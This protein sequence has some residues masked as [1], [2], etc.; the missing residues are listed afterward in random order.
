MLVLCDVGRF[1]WRK[2]SCRCV[3]VFHNSNKFPMLCPWLFQWS[4]IYWCWW[5]LFFFAPHHGREFY[6]W[7]HMQRQKEECL[8]GKSKKCV[9]ILL[10][11]KINIFKWYSWKEILIP[12]PNLSRSSWTHL[13]AKKC[14]AKMKFTKR[15]SSSVDRHFSGSLQWCAS[16]SNQL[17]LEYCWACHWNMHYWLISQLMAVTLPSVLRKLEFIEDDITQQ[18][19]V[20]RFTWGNS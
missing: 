7:K 4:D 11:M 14:D 18:R 13:E 3:S 12:R 9:N 15:R 1:G 5:L 6:I 16:A 19:Y 17:C 8:R 20:D 10:R 2:V